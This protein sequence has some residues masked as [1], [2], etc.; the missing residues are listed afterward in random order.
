MKVRIRDEYVEMRDD[1]AG[2]E[3]G[4]EEKIREVNISVGRLG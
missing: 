4:K 3:L 2:Y 1:D